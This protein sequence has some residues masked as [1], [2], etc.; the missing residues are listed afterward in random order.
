[1]KRPDAKKPATLAKPVSADTAVPECEQRYLGLLEIANEAVLIVCEFHI[2]L[3]SKAACRVLDVPTAESLIGES[4]PELVQPKYRDSVIERISGMTTPGDTAP[5]IHRKLSRPDGKAIDVEIALHACVYRGKPAVQV[6]IRDV[7]EN[8]RL[9]AELTRLAQYDPLTELAN[10]SQ[11]R[12]RLEGAIARATRGKQLV[13]VLCLGLDRFRTINDALGQQGGDVVLM[14]VA[15][16]LKRVVRK[17]DTVAR[18]GSDE[19]SVILE[20]LIDKDGAAI[21]ALRNLSALSQPYNLDGNDISITVSIGIAVFPLDAADID[22]LLRKSLMAM[23]YAKQHGRNQF[24]F[25]STELDA[26]DRDQAQR[27]ND[28]LQR[29]EGLTPRERE[30]ADLLIAGKASKMIAYVL[31]ISSRTIDIHRSRVMEKMQADSLAEL[32]HMM[33]EL[34]S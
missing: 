27:R 10:R 9:Q 13:G 7:T 22:S 17:S 12:D 4:F 1:M 34:D 3:A 29:L 30:V 24:Q 8:L 19:F 14:Q 16:R 20:G 15:E 26:L 32:V 28:L 33:R 25:Y 2:V 5:F 31:G 21:A 23:H 11:Y 18:L 6:L